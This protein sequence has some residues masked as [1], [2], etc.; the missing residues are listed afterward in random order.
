MTKQTFTAA[1]RHHYTPT[2][3]DTI[4]DQ[5]SGHD[6]WR[7]I[8]GKI[9]SKRKR[10]LTPDQREAKATHCRELTRARMLKAQG[11]LH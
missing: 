1:I 6:S 10:T 7:K 9:M 11:L 3:I 8:A 5:L 2:E 4:A